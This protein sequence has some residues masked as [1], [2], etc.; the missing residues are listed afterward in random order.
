M[1]HSGLMYGDRYAVRDG[2]STDSVCAVCVCG[3]GGPFVTVGGEA[4]RDAQPG[5]TT[6][7]LCE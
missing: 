4:G 7:C 1:Y 5:Q 6:T 3:G 2:D